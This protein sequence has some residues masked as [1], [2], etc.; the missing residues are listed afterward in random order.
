[1]DLLAFLSGQHWATRL[2]VQPSLQAK[3]HKSSAKSAFSG[4][5]C[6]L[7]W[8]GRPCALIIEDDAR[9]DLFATS[10]EIELL[11]DAMTMYFIGHNKR[12]SCLVDHCA[13]R[14]LRVSRPLPNCKRP[15]WLGFDFGNVE[16]RIWQSNGLDFAISLISDLCARLTVIDPLM[17][18]RVI[19]ARKLLSLV[20]EA[21]KDRDTL[22]DSMSQ[23]VD[24][25]SIAR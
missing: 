15:P 23:L 4:L 11:A 3:R 22:K 25:L 1:M 2:F 6:F 21:A 7:G 13:V 14:F 5:A 20:N 8:N 18:P 24:S 17:Q 9:D 12:I 10:I 16:L 19:N